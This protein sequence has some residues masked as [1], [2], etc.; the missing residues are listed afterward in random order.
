MNRGQLLTAASALNERLPAVLQIDTGRS[1]CYI[2]NSIEF[3]VG[4]RNDPPDAPAKPATPSRKFIPSSPISPLAKRGRPQ[5]SQL[6]AS[7][8]LLGDVTEEEEPEGHP[9]MTT[10]GQ[11]PLKRRKI[12]QGSVPPAPPRV[13]PHLSTPQNSGSTH[14]LRITRSQ[15]TRATRPLQLPPDRVLRSHSKRVDPKSFTTVT[16][17]PPLSS[18]YT[19]NR[20]VRDSQVQPSSGGVSTSPTDS[21][22]ESSASNTPS[23]A[24]RINC[25]GCRRDSSVER[26]V[27]MV[28]G[29]QRM[30]IPPVD[31][32]D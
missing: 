16:P 17:R 25:R 4:L 23:P 29:L 18:F 22:A 7:P 12:T 3:I 27:G 13:Q 15:S 1:D 28:K 26:E 30:N 6:F 31:S 14:T 5:N 9:I 2:R 20:G 32:D 10:Q 8:S 11:P 19:P 24:P 21:L